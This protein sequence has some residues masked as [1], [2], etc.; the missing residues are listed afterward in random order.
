[1]RASKSGISFAWQ[2][3]LG[4]RTPDDVQQDRLRIDQFQAASG[5]KGLLAV[6]ADGEDHPQAGQV[7][8]EV[9]AGIFESVRT[10]RSSRWNLILQ[11]AIEA[12]QA[13]T[14][15]RG[16]RV[17]VSAALIH[18]GRLYWAHV[19]HSMALLVRDGKARLLTSPQRSLLGDLDATKIALGPA[20]GMAIQTDDRI[21]M[22]TD[23]LMRIRPENGKPYV[24]LAEIAEDVQDNNASEAA[25]HL[26]SVAMGRDVDDNITVAVLHKAPLQRRGSAVWR[27]VG[28]MAIVLMLI[29][30]FLLRWIFTRSDQAAGSDLGY[31]VLIEGQGRLVDADENTGL[32]K[33]DA[34]SPPAKV[35][36]IEDLRLG[37]QSTNQAAV[38]LTAVSLYLSAGSDLQILTID[39]VDPGLQESLM[40]IEQGWA[41]LVRRGGGRSFVFQSAHGSTAL[42]G[43]G[44]G[45]MGGHVDRGALQID[46]IKGSCRVESADGGMINLASGQRVEVS[47]GAIAP[48][49]SI[50]SD[51][52]AQWDALCSGC[53]AGGE[54]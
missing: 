51:E 54:D 23:A 30:G 48:S 29:A 52:W 49:Q 1:M 26:V 41:L 46:C 11:H 14:H 42:E 40:A 50:P 5:V 45:I 18:R 19:G 43:A 53:L 9:I 24:S 27:L 17:A 25:R 38:D 37:F 21:V 2:Q 20:D 44:L 13:I 6:V 12:A 32:R 36:A 3:Q 28:G 15:A 31:A 8:E 10:A 39:V 47:T 4:A 16:A 33:L 35:H 34:I 7:A 22:A